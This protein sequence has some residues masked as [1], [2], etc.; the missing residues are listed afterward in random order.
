M[1]I[2]PPDLAAM[3]A[4]DHAFGDGESEDASDIAQ[5]R[6]ALLD[7]CDALEARI[8]AWRAHQL[9]TLDYVPHPAS[10][11]DRCA[12]EKRREAAW[13]EVMRVDPGWER[14]AEAAARKASK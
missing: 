2:A 7:H 1:T 12:L 8:A 10:I 11:E 3:R 6:H 13:A 14:E 5:D 4:R 9:A